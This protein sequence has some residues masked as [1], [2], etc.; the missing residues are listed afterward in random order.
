MFAFWV[1]V[2]T[3]GGVLP[4]RAFLYVAEV[5]TLFTLLRRVVLLAATTM[6]LGLTSVLWDIHHG[7]RLLLLLLDILTFLSI[8]SWEILIYS[9]RSHVTLTPRYLTVLTHLMPPTS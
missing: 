3:L 1:R 5:H 7:G 9:Y 6:I 2:V 4:C 8:Y